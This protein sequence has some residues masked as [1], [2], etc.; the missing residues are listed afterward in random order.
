MNIENIHLQII[1]HLKNIW[2]F[3][4]EI[5]D[6]YKND[7]K[8]IVISLFFIIIKDVKIQNNRYLLIKS[9]ISSRYLSSTLFCHTCTRMTDRDNFFKYQLKMTVK[10]QQ[11]LFITHLNKPPVIPE[12]EPINKLV[13][14]IGS[15]SGIQLIITCHNSFCVFIYILY[16]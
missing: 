1:K 12:L 9:C 8:K 6:L 5:V 4:I 16:I 10:R 13:L 15:S 14:F 3:V 2:N 11:E 7:T